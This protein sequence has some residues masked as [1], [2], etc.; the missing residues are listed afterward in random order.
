[1]KNNHGKIINYRAIVMSF[2][3]I[4]FITSDLIFAFQ[5]EPPESVGLSSERLDRIDTL[6]N[7]HI[8]KN[9]IAGAITLV[10]RKGK[11][12][13]LKS[14]GNSDLE[15]NIPMKEDT[16]FRIV[17]MTKPITVAALLTLY[18]DGKLLLTDPVSKY[19]PEFKNL[20]V[21]NIKE[22]EKYDISN[23]PTVP[24]DREITILDLLNHT[25]GLPAFSSSPTNELFEKLSSEAKTAKEFSIGLT[26]IPL[27]FQPE[28]EYEYGISYDVLGYLIEVISGKSLDVYFQERIFIPLG[29]NDTYFFVPP[30]KRSRLA[31]TYGLDDNRKLKIQNKH[32]EETLQSTE[33]LSGGGGLK[34]TAMDF[35]RF[36]QMLLNNGQLK[37]KRILS[38]KSVELM[39]TDQVGN[40]YPSSEKGFGWGFG[41]EVRRAL[42]G[43]EIGSVGR[44]GW[45]G[46]LGTEFWIDKQEQMIA[47]ILLQLFP[48]HHLRLQNKFEVLATQAIID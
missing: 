46:R 40:L 6:L 11:V 7:R 24:S 47:I 14:F 13:Y 48:H 28:T 21:L 20:R 9:E 22:G 3:I 4:S 31:A 43:W 25:S 41:G 17:S 29:M 30:N 5:V 19:I 2:L 42:K 44:Y 45:G 23:L 34:T 32:G 8:E 38:R 37:G 35:F 33:F 27:N 12:V 15:Q 26:K 39:M 10:A 16:I 36:S 1:M 18:E